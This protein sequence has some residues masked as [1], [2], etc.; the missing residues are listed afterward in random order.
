MDDERSL[1]ANP[2]GTFVGPDSVRGPE[3]RGTVGPRP[4]SFHV[5]FPYPSRETSLDPSDKDE[6]LVRS[7]RERGNLVEST[8]NRGS[9]RYKKVPKEMT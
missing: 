2:V 5:S 3:N 1:L 7:C 6:V 9:E 4:L 8:K